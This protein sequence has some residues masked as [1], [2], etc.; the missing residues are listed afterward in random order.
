M[1]RKKSRKTSVISGR[2]WLNNSLV[3]MV[4]GVIA[5]G[6]FAFAFGQE[7]IAQY[8]PFTA[9]GSS[10]CLKQFYREEPPFLAK[11]SLQKIPIHCVLMALMSCIQACQKHHCGLL[12]IYHHSA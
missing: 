1:A 10:E 6:S 8:I 12:S 7:K 4:L 3:K 2:N 9:S 11:E 5:T